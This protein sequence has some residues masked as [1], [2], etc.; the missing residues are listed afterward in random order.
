MAVVMDILDNERMRLVKLLAK[1]ESAIS[2]MPRGSISMKKRSNRDYAYLAHREGKRVVF[3][4]VGPASSD[5]VQEL[6][7]M[8]EQRKEL[9]DKV[10]QTKRNLKAVERSLRAGR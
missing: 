4:Y 10:R 6:R 3:D 9:E 7:Q 8:I 5:A 1:Y 2:Q